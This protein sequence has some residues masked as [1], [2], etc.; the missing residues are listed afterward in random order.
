MT[1]PIAAGATPAPAPAPAL[2]APAAATG[3]GVR[4]DRP[5]ADW[6]EDVSIIQPRNAAFWLFVV[7][8]GIGGAS[9][10]DRQLAFANSSTTAWVVGLF[11]LALYAVPV[12]WLVRSLDLFEREPRSML[13]GALLWGGII[14]TYLAAHVNDQWG[15]ILNKVAGADFAREW[16][17]ALIGPGDEELFKFLGVVVLFLIARAEFDDVLDGFVYGAIIGLG[18]TL[19]EDMYYFFAHFVGQAGASDLGGLFDGFFTRI[20]VGGPYSHVLL[21]GLTGMG[22]AYFVTRPDVPRQRRLL[23]A[24]GLYVAGVAAHFIWNSPLLNDFLGNDPDATTWILWAAMKGLPFLILLAVIVRMAQR[25]EMRWVRAAVAP[26]VEAG[27]I[28]PAELDTL[29]DLRRRRAARAVEK[30]R[31]G[32]A[33][34]RLLA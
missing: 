33:G 32:A 17:A 12:F 14:A 24:I 3:P 31:S 25:R 13:I 4:P 28:T 22:L 7:L 30:A 26:E 20:I 21:T 15:E 2:P 10:I 5:P 23:A 29:G 8:L 9:F 27:Y 6:S 11:L 19:E 34:E 16:G 18:F 1:E